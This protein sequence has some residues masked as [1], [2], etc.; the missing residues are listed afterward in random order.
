[1]ATN[2]GAELSRQRKRYPIKC[3]N[4]GFTFA[5]L[6]TQLDRAANGLDVYCPGVDGKPSQCRNTGTQRRRRA[7]LRAAPTD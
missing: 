5:G 7:R 4:C 6:K 2:P 1:M 3:S